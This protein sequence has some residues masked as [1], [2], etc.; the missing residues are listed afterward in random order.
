MYIKELNI[1]NFMSL[2]LTLGFASA[3]VHAPEFRSQKNSNQVSQ[4]ETLPSTLESNSE[5]K[6]N[7][8]MRLICIS[9]KI[10]HL[11]SIKFYTK[12]FCTI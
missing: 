6:K 9:N 1:K 7:K 11:N 10:K 3:C 4:T 12:H 8:T 2:F 5:N